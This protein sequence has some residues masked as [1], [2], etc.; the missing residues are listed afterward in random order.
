MLATL[1]LSVSLGTACG[2][3][4]I[5]RDSPGASGSPGTAGGKPNGEAGGVHVAGA[6]NGGAANGGAA[7][8]GA[9]NGGAANGGAA[10][11]GAANGG[12]AVACPAIACGEGGT[13]RVPPGECCPVCHSPCQDQICPDVTCPAGSEEAYQGLACCPSCLPFQRLDC[14]T[15]QTHYELFRSQLVDK[16]A[17]G[18]RSAADCLTVAPANLCESGC[19]YVAISSFAL[20]NLNSNLGS[21]AK[22][23]CVDCGQSPVPPCDAPLPPICK[24]G[25]CTLG[26]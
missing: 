11:G 23:D 10:N 15:G 3:R 16:Y 19:R 20:D 1:G 4:S 2:G 7:N 13:L 8:G 26:N 9:A 14:A 21:A 5:D 25:A 22:T 6:A 24:N 12:A 18:C 17:Q